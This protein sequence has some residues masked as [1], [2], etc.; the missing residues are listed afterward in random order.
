M[1]ASPSAGYI[2][3]RITVQPGKLREFRE[4]LAREYLPGAR[5]RG[6]ALAGAWIEPP[7]ELHDESNDLYLL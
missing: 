1:T 2:L 7:L 5:E 6:L 4:R 3:D